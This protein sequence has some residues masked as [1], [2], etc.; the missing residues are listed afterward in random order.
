MM[1]GQIAED[2]DEKRGNDSEVREPC[3]EEVMEHRTAE[4][5]RQRD[6]DRVAPRNVADEGDAG[7]ADAMIRGR[8]L[9]LLRKADPR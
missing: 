8:A 2:V 6:R 3:G 1:T 4:R 7:R 9:V 5:N